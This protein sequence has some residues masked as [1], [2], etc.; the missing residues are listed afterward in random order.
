MLRSYRVFARSFMVFKYDKMFRFPVYYFASSVFSIEELLKYKI[1][2]YVWSYLIIIIIII[3]MNIRI[4]GLHKFLLSAK[5]MCK[6]G[7]YYKTF[8]IL[9]RVLYL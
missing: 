6:K 3:K 1:K 7:V 2:R 4:S 5:Y 9:Q 8:S